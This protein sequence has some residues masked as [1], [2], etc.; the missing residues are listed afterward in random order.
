MR[1]SG[2]GGA[3][4]PAAGSGV[5]GASVA[6]AETAAASEIGPCRSPLSGSSETSVPAI[7]PSRSFSAQLRSLVSMIDCG[8]RP[9]TVVVVER[10][11]QGIGGHQIE[12][13]GDRVRWVARCHR[14]G[15]ARAEHLADARGV[16]DDVIAHFDA[17][18]LEQA[19]EVGQ[20]ALPGLLGRIDHREE[21]AAS[22]EV[23]LEGLDLAR[24]EVGHR[25]GDDDR[26]RLV[27]HGGGLREHELLE[28]VVVALERLGDGAV[29]VA[30]AAG[31]ILLAVAL[32]EIDHP[33][34]AGR[35]LDEGVGDVLLLGLRD[36]LDA[37]LVLEHEG[38]GRGDAC[39]LGPGRL[40]I[41]VHVLDRQLLALVGVFLEPVLDA[42]EARGQ[43]VDRELGRCVEAAQHLQRLLR[44]AEDL[45]GGEVPPLVLPDA[46]VVERDE[47]RQHRDDARR[48]TSC[49]SWSRARWR[50]SMLRATAR[51][52]RRGCT[53]APPTPC[54]CDRRPVPASGTA[55][56]RPPPPAPCRPSRRLPQSCAMISPATVRCPRTWP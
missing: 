48:S 3:S 55:A 1:V 33:L 18:L 23:L 15:R 24:E 25:P 27:G 5:V 19:R 36:A 9:S 20:R 47:D 52:G 4:V 6:G 10:S 2:L 38:A 13:L 28:A 46:E 16:D 37:A 21:R 51:R 45:V 41:E 53:P 56:R 40:A 22:G 35:R 50:R 49:P 43:V 42:V 39:G 54:R 11:R 44:Q 29:A 30:L 12:A 32:R 17:P 14:H 31:R 34:L 8:V 26:R 7:R